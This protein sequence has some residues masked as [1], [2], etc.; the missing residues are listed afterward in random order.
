MSSHLSV[1]C[2]V[3]S[4]SVVSDFAT[5]WTVAR[6]VPWDSPGKNTG[7]GGHA[8]LQGILPTQGSI[9]GLPHCRQIIYCL[10]HQ[11]SPFSLW[12]RATVLKPGCM[13]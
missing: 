5:P 6:Q 3:L 12:S 7:M 9:P 1:A 10:S 8:F 2:A 13:L 11:G 4:R